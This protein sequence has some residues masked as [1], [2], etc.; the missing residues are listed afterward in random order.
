MPEQQGTRPWKYTDAV[1]QEAAPLTYRA[2]DYLEGLL[3]EAIR[4]MESDN[5]AD[6]RE[7]GLEQDR[8]FGW[9]STMALA[10]IVGD[11]ERRVRE[12]EARASN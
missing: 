12:L 8:V 9:M 4:L 1:D 10:E 2:L 7:G 5:I 11:L 6:K 3:L